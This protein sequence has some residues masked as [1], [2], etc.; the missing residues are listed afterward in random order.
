MHKIHTQCTLDFWQPPP[1]VRDFVW[2]RM[3]G[4]RHP[5]HKSV[6]TLCMAAKTFTLKTITKDYPKIPLK[7]NNWRSWGSFKLQKL[8]FNFIFGTYVCKLFD[9]GNAIRNSNSGRSKGPQFGTRG[10]QCRTTL[11]TYH[12]QL[13]KTATC[14]DP[15]TKI[16]HAHSRRFFFSNCCLAL[17]I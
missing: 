11:L 1:C 14:N 15:N 3:A 13:H 12:A 4:F 10:L 2:K 17:H 7:R 5:H 16:T 6:R 9:G 8:P